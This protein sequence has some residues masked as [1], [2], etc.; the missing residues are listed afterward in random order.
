MKLVK[1]LMEEFRKLQAD[2]D[3][4]RIESKI[5][6]AR[7]I[8]ELVKFRVFPTPTVIECLE[9]CIQDF[10]GHNIEVACAILEACGRFLYRNVESRW[11]VSAMLEILQRVKKS[12]NFPPQTEELIEHAYFSCRPKDKNAHRRERPLLFEYLRYLVFNLHRDNSESTISIIRSLPMDQCQTYL[13]K[14]LLSAI[15]KGKFNQIHLLTNMLAGLKSYKPM[16]QLTTLLVDMMIEEILADLRLNDFRRNQHRTIVMRFFGEL[17]SYKMITKE[18]IFDLLYAVIY[19]GNETDSNRDSFRVRL[20]CIL[21]DTCGQYFT[22]PKYKPM[23]DRFLVHFQHY[24]LQKT[25]LPLDLEFMVLDTLEA[26]HPAIRIDPGSDSSAAVM[27]A[28][29]EERENTAKQPTVESD[30]EQEIE[31]EVSSPAV[32]TESDSEELRFEREFMKAVEESIDQSRARVITK[33]AVKQA[34][35][36]YV[37][38]GSPVKHRDGTVFKLLTKKAG[39]VIPKSFPVPQ[40]SLFAQQASER[41]QNELKEREELS[42]RVCDLH[43][44]QHDDE[45]QDLA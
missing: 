13:L 37:E 16:D 34:P 15:S 22:I 20:A 44:R 42:R 12:K 21:L 8:G 23:L 25:E 39:K 33:D 19:Y 11:R 1:R 7:F 2:N 35:S 14:A 17:Y 18:T 3:P 6:N 36:A 29:D 9:L 24:V 28:L 26:L 45:Q 4:L 30:S 27:R 31:V 40:H 32:V 38:M 5:K 41:I 10:A 43:D